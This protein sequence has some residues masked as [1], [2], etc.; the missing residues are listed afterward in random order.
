MS[1]TIRRISVSISFLVGL[2]L[3]TVACCSWDR[4]TK[5]TTCVAPALLMEAA[6]AA[7]VVQVG[8]R[9]VTRML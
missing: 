1:L 2:G 4:T 5:V 9:R 6:A 8:R 3:S 7:A